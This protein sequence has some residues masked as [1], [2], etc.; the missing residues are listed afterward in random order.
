MSALIDATASI[1]GTLNL[2]EVLQAIARSAAAVMRAEASSVLLL[3]KRRKKL[4]FLAAVGDRSDLIIGEAFDADKGIAGKV[5]STGVPQCVEDVQ[6]SRIFNP[7]IDAKSS[8]ETRGLIAAP[9]VYRGDVL[10]VVE[11]LNPLG[12]SRFTSEDVALLQVFANLAATGCRNAQEHETLKQEYH[13]LQA[14][15]RAGEQVIGSSP[16]FSR[17]LD[18]CKRVA[19]SNATVLLLGETGTGKEVA[20]RRIHSLSPRADR[21]FVATNC[22][23]LPETLLESELFGHEKG[24]F[25]GAIAE[26][27]GRFEMADGGTL[28]LDEIGDISVPTQIKLLRVLQEREIV[29]VGGTETITID[30]R[31]LAATN[32]DLKKAIAEGTFREDLFYR[33]NVFPIELPPLRARREDIPALIEHF[34]RRSA[35][36]LG[37]AEPSVSNDA[38]VALTSYHWPGNIRELQNVVERTVLLTDSGEVTPEHLPREIVGDD[39]AALANPTESGLAGYEKVLIVKALKETDWNQTR[40]AASLG[41]SRDNLRYRVKKYGIVKPG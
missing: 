17:V 26:K 34:V 40:A 23:A 27:I 20:A 5:V 13:G 11:V 38:M 29:R 25:T 3:D 1:N 2:R 28:F 41:I 18:L 12:D 33:L 31:I 7:E 35:R 10:G 19:G 14:T 8:F 16:A 32:R 21:P 37:V 9:L 6:D 22:A 4:V 24:A 36:D 30:A 39:A 15:V